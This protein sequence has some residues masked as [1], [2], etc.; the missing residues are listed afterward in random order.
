MTTEFLVP[1]GL[2]R[3]SRRLVSPTDA[4]K[5]TSYRCPQCEEPLLLRAGTE[6]IRRHFAH[7]ADT[8]CGKESL[9]HK[10]AKLLL[11]QTIREHV[12]GEGSAQIS[13]QCICKTCA[14]A[15]TRSLPRRAFER[16][17][18]E[19]PCG[20]FRFDVAACRGESIALG[21]EILHTH[22]VPQDKAAEITVPWVELQ[23]V[24]V[25]EHPL[26]WKPVNSRLRP[27]ECDDCKSRIER[28]RALAEKLRFALEPGAIEHDHKR[29]RY[30][31]AIEK[32]WSCKQDIL[33]FWWNGVPFCESEPPSPR[34][35]TI[36]LRHSKMFSGKYWANTCPHCKSIQGDNFLFLGFDGSNRPF[37]DLPLREGPELKLGRERARQGVVRFLLRNIR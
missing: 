24:D 2:E 36:Q 12:A 33:V 27:V 22:V 37:R 25:L 6:R 3:I 20:R 5:E 19:V 10:T 23:A 29:A 17:E 1:F 30:L 14:A 31:P 7:R 32:C 4:S 18:V 9:L 26:Q 8:N 15:F 35:R 28:I 21:I 34:P 16:P 11:A 13:M